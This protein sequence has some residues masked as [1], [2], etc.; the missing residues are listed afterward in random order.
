MSAP[1]ETS[2]AVSRHFAEVSRQILHIVSGL[3]ALCLRWVGPIPLILLAGAA[4]LFNL[5]L[6]PRIGGRWLWRPEEIARGRA[7]GVVIYP[8]TVLILLLV[9]FKRPEV[10]AAG[11]GLLAFGDG[12]ATLVGSRWGR[13]ALPWNRDKSWTGFLAFFVVGWAAVTLLVAWTV[14]GKYEMGFLM[15]T[16]A[17]VA[18][19]AG[20][21]ESAPQ[22]L[23][24]N[25]AAP[26]VA[27]LFLLC[28]LETSGRWG[29]L[30]QSSFARGLILGLA[31]NAIFALAAYLL[32]TL[33]GWGALVA[34]VLGTVVFTFVSWRGYAVLLT[35]FVLGALSTR[36]GHERKRQDS[37]AGDERGRRRA[38]NA[39]ANGS[40][41]AACAVFAGV[42]SHESVFVAAFACSLAAAA[43]DTVESE[44]GRVWG[45]PT[46]LITTWKPVA[47][48]VDGGI[49]PAGTIAGLLAA[50]VTVVVGSI[51]GLYPIAMALPLSLLALVATLAESVA[52]AT[53][54]TADLLNNDGVNFLN[55][56][57]AAVLGA[58]WIWIM[59]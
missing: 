38:A 23:D 49:S 22:R 34:C 30:L 10:A 52:G 25:L 17:V 2:R 51:A 45:R 3:W 32:A 31:L 58:G 26:L 19:L 59:G 13:V 24:D 56:L 54:E 33:D 39:L 55:T 12:A 48:G 41:A 53:L 44:I 8:L 11:W 27:A 7:V 28:I 21:L 47:P 16:G 40:V 4:L 43:A 36:L 9:F 14:P 5:W 18:L 6:L 50:L 37:V 20:L 42:G 46:V 1:V 35:F 57:L 29:E 15:V